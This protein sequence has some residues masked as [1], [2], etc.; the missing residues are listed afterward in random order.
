MP[1]IIYCRTKKQCESLGS[2][3]EKHSIKTMV[4]HADIDNEL[5]D[6]ILQSW[7]SDVVQIIV[8]TIAFGLGV[9][10]PNVRFV[11]HHSLPAS[12]DSYWQACG[13]AGYSL[14]L[15]AF[16]MYLMCLCVET[17]LNDISNPFATSKP[18][19]AIFIY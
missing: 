5:K 7:M 12:A 9:N 1:G 16:I 10:K 2:S 18:S 19:I 3:L 14:L 15:S 8:A 6:T 4:Y 13:R 11:V 17:G